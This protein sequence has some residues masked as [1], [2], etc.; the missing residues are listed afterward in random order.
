MQQPRVMTLRH[1]QLLQ[2]AIEHYQAAD[3]EDLVARF[4]DFPDA[5]CRDHIAGSR[6]TACRGIGRAAERIHSQP[7]RTRQE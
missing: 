6:Q 4:D 1:A 5:A 2:P 3:V 7:Q